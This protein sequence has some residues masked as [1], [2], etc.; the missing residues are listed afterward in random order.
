MEQ[1]NNQQKD[2][3]RIKEIL[4]GEDLQELDVRLGELREEMDGIVQNQIKNLE[5]KLSEQEMAHK[6]EMEA[7]VQLL[8]QEKQDKKRLEKE[9]QEA[10]K[11]METSIDTNA[12]HFDKKLETFSEQQHKQNTEMLEA[13]KTNL[14]DRIKQLEESKVNKAEIAELF[15]LMIQKLK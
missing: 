4:L 1:G 10:W 2:L 14:L 8:E 9:W 3:S 6:K 5:E 11:K 13:L 15:G 12:V 7:I